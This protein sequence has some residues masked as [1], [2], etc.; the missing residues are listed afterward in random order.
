MFSEQAFKI[1]EES[2]ED[3]HVKDHVDQE[4]VNRYDSGIERLLYRKNWID[5]VQWHY[6]DIIRDPQ[7][8]PEEALQLKRKIDASNQDR[9]DL[10]EYIDSYFLQKYQSV[11]VKPDATINTESPAWA[12]DRLSILA[13]KIYHMREEVERKDA[14]AAHVQKCQEKLNV[15]LEQKKDLSTAINQLLADIEN[16]DKYMKVYKQMKMYNDDELNPV[17]RGQKG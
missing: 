9:T 14:S 3:Y 5:T 6:E 13:L 17:L 16:G 7:I 2:I 11:D 15:L 10:V 8:E 12:I 4:F 1:F